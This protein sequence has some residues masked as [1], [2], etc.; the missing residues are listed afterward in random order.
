MGTL[1]PGYGSAPVEENVP[2]HQVEETRPRLHKA[3]KNHGENG[4]GSGH[5]GGW[6]VTY[7]DMITL[8]MA[9]FIMIITFSS[10]DGEKGIES[11][12]PLDSGKNGSGLIGQKPRGYESEEVIV[13]VRTR[14]ARIAGP[15][16]ETAPLYTN[17]S[18][19]KTKQ[20]FDVLNRPP[21]GTLADNYRL[22]V[23]LNA[24]FDEKDRVSYQGAQLLGSIAANLR[25]LPYDV[26]ILTDRPNQR[27]LAIRVADYLTHNAGFPPGRLAV[28][29]WTPDADRE[30]C[31]WFVFGR[32]Q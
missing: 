6:L 10:R 21:I 29:T 19:E 5:G 28:G 13:R 7:C 23:P 1:P 11:K 14:Q 30:N 15:N 4:H 32:Q 17:P 8:L 24:L 18:L 9:C 22:C 25:P 16:S 3:G 26:Q 31:L 12:T 2:S 27:P 20:V